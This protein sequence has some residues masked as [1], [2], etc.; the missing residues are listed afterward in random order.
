MSDQKGYNVEED[1]VSLNHTCNLFILPTATCLYFTEFNYILL[2]KVSIMPSYTINSIF[3]PHRHIIMS[4]DG[5]LISG[6]LPTRILQELVFY[7]KYQLT[8]RL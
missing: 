7:R 4:K 1:V 5:N 6:R 3:Y 2:I 8:I